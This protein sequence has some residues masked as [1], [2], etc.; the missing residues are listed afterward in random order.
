MYQNFPAQHP[1][2]FRNTQHQ[3]DFEKNGF[4]IIPFY[5]VDKIKTLYDLYYK[6]CP[7]NEIGFFP[8]TFSK[9]TNYRSTVDTEIRK[10][11][12][13]IISDTFVNTKTVCGSFIVKKPGNGSE[14]GIHQD[15]TLVDESKWCGINI[16]CPLCNLTKHN[17]TLYVLPKSNRLVPTLRGATIPSIYQDGEV[18][19]LIKKYAIPIYLK[20]GQAIAFD[21][22]IIHFSP[23]NLTNTD[24]VVTNIYLTHKDARFITAY[25][26][27]DNF[28]NFVEL[29]EQPD[30]FFTNFEQFGND[31]M[32]KPTM[33]KSMGKVPY[34]FPQLTADQL[35][36]TYTTTKPIAHL[37]KKI[38]SYARTNF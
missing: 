12:E 25:W 3:S 18:Q 23:P 7:V 19:S 29:F 27:K 2:F 4:V 32:A 31:I 24:R 22:S 35:R 15:M 38:F 28:G 14:M 10:T 34:H 17:G 30:D 36:K 20:A 37:L 8:S 1:V 33:G 9:D 6:L 21:P 13:P 16:W 11:A 5:N 26:D